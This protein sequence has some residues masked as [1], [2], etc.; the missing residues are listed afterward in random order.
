MYSNA[1]HGLTIADLR[2][3]ISTLSALKGHQPLSGNGHGQS[4][5][6]S[7]LAAMESTTLEEMAAVALLD[8]EETK[9]VL[10]E[11]D[12]L[13][14]LPCL[15]GEYRV[16][17]IDGRRVHGYMSLYFDT[18]DFD[19]YH[20]HH[21]GGKHRY[22]IRS[23][24]YRDTRLSFLEI[25]HKID[26]SHTIKNRVQTPYMLTHLCP[27]SEQFVRSHFPFRADGL[28]PKLWNSY[29]RLTLISRRYP[30]RLTIDFHPEFFTSDRAQTLPGIVIAEVKYDSTHRHS[31]FIRLM[32]SLGI[33]PMG[34][35]KYCI[36]VALLHAEHVKSNNFKPTLRAVRQLM[37]GQLYEQ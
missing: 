29:Q 33:R 31:E 5:L 28:E 17:E 16:L 4:G 9:F 12:L 26:R 25:K 27:D 21:A 7:I 3:E 24:Q 34:F 30:E 37:R 1:L 2:R 20:R 10:R 8:R 23:R 35:S 22:K 14:V 32:R 18:P 6:L 13:S 15:A 19:L 11:H 36:G